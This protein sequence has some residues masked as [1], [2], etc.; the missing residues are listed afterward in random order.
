MTP[1]AT[2]QIQTDKYRVTKSTPTPQHRTQEIAGGSPKLRSVKS[3]LDKI[4][5]SK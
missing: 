4:N 2:I 5:N 3:L 1:Y